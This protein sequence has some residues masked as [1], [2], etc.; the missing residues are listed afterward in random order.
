MKDL[1][2]IRIY[3]ESGQ[4]IEEQTFWRKFFSPDFSSELIKR[5]KSFGIEQV[6]HLHVSKGYVNNQKINWGVS[7]IR[8]YSHPHLIEIID[9]EAKIN[10]FLEEQKLLIQGIKVI[11]VKSEVLIKQ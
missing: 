11:I 9:T 1:I 10:Q 3:F 2:T 8:H 5:A 6:I 7:E 4:K